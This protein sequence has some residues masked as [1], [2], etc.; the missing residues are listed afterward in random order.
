MEGEVHTLAM[1][2]SLAVAEPRAAPPLA[3]MSMPVSGRELVQQCATSVDN[4][5]LTLGDLLHQK[6]EQRRSALLRR[7]STPTTAFAGRARGL[8][9]ASCPSWTLRC[10]VS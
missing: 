1:P 7:L 2:S 10:R 8:H 4:L 5:E 3:T 6:E 9:R